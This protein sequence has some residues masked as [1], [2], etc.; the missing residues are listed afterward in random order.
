M[1][2]ETIDGGASHNSASN[3]FPVIEAET[4]ITIL[5]IDAQYRRLGNRIH[6]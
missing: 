3:L 1:L 5:Q 4:L 2:S 6:P